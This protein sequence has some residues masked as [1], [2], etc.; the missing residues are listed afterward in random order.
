MRE[1]APA[2]RAAVGKRVS[3]GTYHHTD[4]GEA[5]WC[6]FA[7]KIYRVGRE[8]GLVR[9][10]EEIIPVPTSEYPTPARRPRYCLLDCSS[11]RDAF[12]VEADLWIVSV[13]R[14]LE[15]IAN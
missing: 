15:G 8:L 12:G 7:R 13:R 14:K 1:L 2:I 9:S 11:T 5:T 4:E 3:G 10:D 6:E